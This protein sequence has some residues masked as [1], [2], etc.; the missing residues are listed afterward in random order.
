MLPALEQLVPDAIARLEHA[1]SLAG[2]LD[3]RLLDSRELRLFVD[4]VVP[5][6]ERPRLLLR[7]I[8]EPTRLRED[9]ALHRRRDLA[10]SPFNE[11]NG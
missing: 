9:G 10:S 6:S 7:K 5:L 8:E 11:N 1:S 3:P 4:A 2:Q